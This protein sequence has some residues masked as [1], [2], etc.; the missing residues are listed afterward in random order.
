M[1][2]IVM[3]IQHMQYYQN[4]NMTISLITFSEVFI[5]HVNLNKIS[6]AILEN[7]MRI[8]IDQIKNIKIVN[9]FNS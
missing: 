1:Y 4:I 5:Y 6:T 9:V 2:L 3:I 8:I 7:L